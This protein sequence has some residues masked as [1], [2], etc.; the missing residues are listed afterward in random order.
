VVK[1]A[2]LSTKYYGASCWEK[3]RAA[4]CLSNKLVGARSY[5]CAQ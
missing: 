2:R 3:R 4:N 1:I 5:E